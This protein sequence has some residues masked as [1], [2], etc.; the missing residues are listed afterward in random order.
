MSHC[1]KNIKTPAL[2]ND[3]AKQSQITP[4]PKFLHWL[5]VEQCVQFKIAINLN[6]YEQ[7]YLGKPVDIEQSYLRKPVDIEQS[8]VRKPVDI[9]QRVVKPDLHT[10]PC[11]YLPLVDSKL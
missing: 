3:T 4:A 10:Q 8:Y 11:L 5:T 7:S 2:R 6:K 1:I 9:E